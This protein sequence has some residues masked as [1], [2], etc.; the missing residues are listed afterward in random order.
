VVEQQLGAGTFLHSAEHVAALAAAHPV[1]VV[2]VFSGEPA[3]SQL[4]DFAKACQGA[5]QQTGRG[6]LETRRAHAHVACAVTTAPLPLAHGQPAA[7]VAGAELVVF[8]D[9][10]VSSP[11][12]SSPAMSVAGHGGGGLGP[13]CGCARSTQRLRFVGQIPTVARGC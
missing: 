11:P 2:G 3:P 10:Q 4:S 9:G 12:V 6:A 7:V 13:S 1:A 5:L 8:I